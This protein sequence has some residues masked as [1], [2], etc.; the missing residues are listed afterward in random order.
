M[1][2]ARTLA[3]PLPLHLALL[4]EP[5]G[6]RRDCP[7][8]W[9]LDDILSLTLGWALGADQIPQDSSMGRDGIP[10]LAAGDVVAAGDAQALIPARLY[11]P[12]D[13]RWVE[14]ACP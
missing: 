9:S 11:R 14:G 3:F 2:R 1:N 4:K 12:E 6:A 13:M 7:G 10:V 8:Q 5:L